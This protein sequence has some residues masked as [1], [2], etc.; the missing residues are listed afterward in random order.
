MLS[1]YTILGT[2]KVFLD[3]TGP[4]NQLVWYW[5]ADSVPSMIQKMKSLEIAT[6]KRY[7]D[8]SVLRFW[9][10][11]MISDGTDSCLILIEQDRLLLVLVYHPVDLQEWNPI[12]LLQSDVI[13]RRYRDLIESAIQQNSNVLPSHGF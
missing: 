3:R 2:G 10:L 6:G 13:G 7:K 8:E 4:A 5:F 1:T 12:G 9:H 11:N